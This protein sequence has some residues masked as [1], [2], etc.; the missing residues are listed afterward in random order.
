MLVST[1]GYALMSVATKVSVPSS[2][3][4]TVVFWRSVSV[5]LIAF[6]IARHRGISLRPKA[7]GLLFWR[8]VAGF[9]AMLCYFWALGS[10]PIA[11][12]SALLYTNPIFIVILAGVL[13]GERVPR[14]TLTTV[15]VAFCGLLLLIRPDLASSWD[16]NSLF[17]LAAG[18]LAA[19][20][21]LAIRK[22]RE[23]ETSELIVVYFASFSVVLSSPW[24]WFNGLPQSLEAWSYIALVGLGAAVGQL[25]MTKAYHLERASIVGPFSYATVVWNTV[26]GVIVFGES[27]SL[28]MCAG[29]ALII[30]CGVRLSQ[31]AAGQQ[32]AA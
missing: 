20:A 30:A 9:I 29:I 12:A 25:A 21:Y 1:V 11:T 31:H 7:H 19:L 5:A 18:L 22:L 8:S 14:G 23:S 15:M 27:L 3:L 13:L 32:R 6:G 17:A 16:P 10:V 4:G 28:T 26:I 2:G 24:A